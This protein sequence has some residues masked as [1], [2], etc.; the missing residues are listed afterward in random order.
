MTG[1]PIVNDAQS[2][3]N[4]PEFTV[5]ELAGAI[6]RALEDR[7]G[8][9]RL[10]GEVSGFRGPHSSGHCYFALKDEK[11][12]IDAVVWRG[13]WN[14]LKV[15]PEEGLEV[16]VQGRVTTFP[17]SSKYQI[18]VEAMEPAGV[19]ALMALLEARKKA[20]A[21]E[22]LFDEAKKKKLPFLPG[23]VGVVTSPTGAV[24]RDIVRCLDQRF[25]V[26]V[27]VWP[28]RV[29]GDTSAAEVA[30]AITGFNAIKLGGPVPR[31]DVLIVARG[32]G[33]LEDLWGFNEEA[34]AR[35]AAASEIPLISAVGHETDWTLIDLAADLR[36]S[37]PTM[38]A[39]WAV[40]KRADL[41]EQ[42]LKLTLRLG[43]AVRRAT[44]AARAN[45]KGAARGLPRLQELL[46][47]PR[48]RFDF[49]THQLRQCFSS[50]VEKRGARLAQV[51]ARRPL[52]RSLVGLPRQRF[53]ACE[54]RLARALLAN[55]RAHGL[56]HGRL[57]ARLSPGILTS[58]ASRS[59]ERLGVLEARAHQAVKNR[60]SHRRR[61]LDGQA[62]LLTSL[63]YQSVL[64][65]GYAVVRKAGGS[66]ARLAAEVG[67]GDRLEIEFTD[68]RVHVE[69]IKGETPFK[70]PNAAGDGKP[71]PSRPGPSPK[72]PRD[73]GQDSLF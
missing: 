58:R 64:R 6:K 43:A 24:I 34:V 12:K 32:G 7:F 26:R 9:V 17:N 56:R 47:T 23:V 14:K 11:A 50:F 31:P 33:S 5:S 44:I 29:Q 70:D 36:A 39:E 13:V 30:A 49:A 18:V 65:R 72:Q 68:G 38:A 48:Q 37:T 10:K 15:K 40:P 41:A 22:G 73:P 62:K 59:R 20:L 28:V 2:P 25:P 35:A 66:M 46:A 52:A 8:Y 27:I 3:T 69:A 45:W 55:T 61:Q 60:A 1:R 42:T 63:S 21:A 53:D 67:T 19:G 16:V 57:A 54:R 51:A 4:A 71:Q